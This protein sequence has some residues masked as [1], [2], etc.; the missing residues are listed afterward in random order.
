VST[1]SGVRNWRV[2]ATTSEY[3]QLDVRRW[4]RDGLLT[5]G[6][7]F[8]WKWLQEGTEVA[9]THVLVESGRVILSHNFR[10][11]AAEPLQ[12]RQYSVPV[13]WTRCNFS[14]FRAWFQCPVTGCGRRVA[15]LYLSEMF[16]CRHCCHI[17]YASQREPAH[18][19]AMNKARAILEK[20]GGSG[21]MSEPFP[22]KP[23]GMHRRTYLRL[24]S[25]YD[26]AARR[27]LPQRKHM[28]VR[29]CVGGVPRAKEPCSRT[30]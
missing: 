21:D 27:S 11:N 6:R 19:R 7:C 24:R 20:I 29:D 15:I 13:Q 26:E 23:K 12:S 28:T 22:K 3:Y 14:G 18:L 1:N 5:H 25:A 9:S 4:Q 2:K 8:E 30:I 17:V 16:A 10:R